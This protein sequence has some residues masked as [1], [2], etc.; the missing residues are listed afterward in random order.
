MNATICKLD[1]AVVSKPYVELS[2]IRCKKFSIDSHQVF[3]KKIIHDAEL[4]K[5]FAA[6]RN[7][8]LT[9]APYMEQLINFVKG[10]FL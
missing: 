9:A 1:N 4:Q 3:S 8:I 10:T 7:L 2:H 6:N 5:R